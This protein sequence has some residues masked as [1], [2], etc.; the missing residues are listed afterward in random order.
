[1]I[2]SYEL[3]GGWL[4]I[5]RAK[6]GKRAFLG[7][8]GMTAPGPASC[9]KSGLVAVLSAAPEK[10]KAGHVVAG[11]PAGRAAPRRRRRRRRAA[12]SRRPPR[13]QG[14]ARRWSSSAALIAGRSSRSRSA[15]A[16]V[17]V[18][19]QLLARHGLGLAA[20]LGGPVVLV[21]AAV[22]AAAGHRSPSGCWSAACRAGRSTRC[23]APSSGA[24]RWPTPS[25]RWSRCRGSL[26]PHARARR[27][28]PCGCARSVPASAGASGARPTGCPSPTWSRSATAPRVNRGCVLQTHLFHDRIMSMDTVTLGRR[29]DARPARRHPPGGRARRRRPTVG[30]ASLV[31]RGDTVPPATPLDRQPDRPV[32]ADPWPDSRDLR[33]GAGRDPLPARPRRRRATT[34]S[35]Y[36]LDLDYRVA[37]NHLDGPGAAS[38]SRP[39]PEVDRYRPR[40]APACGVQQGHRR[41]PPA[42]AATSTAAGKLIRSQLASE[43]PAGTAAAS[44]RSRYAGQPRPMRGTWGERRL[45]GADRRRHRRGP[46]RRCAV[47]V[48]VQRPTRRQGR[49]TASPSPPSRRTTWWPT[50]RLV[51]QRAAVR[52]A[53]R[54]STSSPSRWRPTWPPCRSAATSRVVVAGAPGAAAR[55][56]AARLRAQL[57][58]STSAASRR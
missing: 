42:G 44:S 35:R 38:P 51:E 21:A 49:P 28:S 17:L 45:G 33:L 39:A 1:M 58:T 19:E 2:G 13:L 25:S 11:Q 54:G 43:A 30:P 23:G 34:S 57:R 5:E 8:S 9:R 41:R 20:L 16:V 14:G 50:A 18:L 53:P 37:S 55:R 48:P 7:N 4:R 56:R 46:A 15:L 24:T 22:A 10:A 26:R 3:G 32:G 36:D 6:V 52:A 40:P 29:R 31:M 47:L 27:C 12:P